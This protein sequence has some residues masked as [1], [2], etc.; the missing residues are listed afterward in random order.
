MKRSG[1]IGLALATVA[2]LF[3]MAGAPVARA[4]GKNPNILVIMGGRCR[5]I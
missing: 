5:L 4:Q 1:R 3:G 2:T